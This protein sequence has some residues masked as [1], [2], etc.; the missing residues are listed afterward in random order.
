MSVQDSVSLRVKK[1]AQIISVQETDLL[2]ALQ[3]AGIEDSNVGLEVLNSP[4]TTIKD[5][6]EIIAEHVGVKKEIPTKAAAN[7]LKTPVNAEPS[8]PEGT[9]TSPTTDIA[10]LAQSLKPIQQ[11]DDKA[12]LENFIATRSEE[13]ETE[14][15]RRA[16]HN[17]FVVLKDPA[18]KN[19]KRYEPGK[20]E[21]DVEMTLKLL[22]DSRKRTTPGILPSGDGFVIVYRITELNVL[23]RIVE[24]CPLCGEIL[25]QGYCEKCQLNFAEVGEDELAYVNLISESDTFRKDSFSDRVA[26]LR[27]A[28]K[29][30]EDLKT[31]WPSLAQKFDELKLLGD[32][33]KLKKSKSLP[34]SKPADPFHVAGNRSF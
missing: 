24:I 27:S 23:D 26:V 7:A 3:D 33:P 32:L 22:K 8:I 25:Y 15:D 20:E 14:L 31:T 30:I 10:A 13:S 19:M 16:K 11:W 17:K 1:A 28:M 2:K 18:T 5:L 21:I 12:L 4:T 29:G 34:S 9:S 6:V